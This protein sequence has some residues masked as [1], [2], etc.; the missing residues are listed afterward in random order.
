MIRKRLFWVLRRGLL[1]L[2]IGGIYSIFLQKT[3]IGF[4]C[5]INFLTGL[6]CPGCGVSHMCIALMQLDFAAAFQANPAI[7][8]LSPILAAVL[9]QYLMHYIK[10]G[11]WQMRPAQNMIL[12]FCIAVLFLYGIG[13]NLFPL[14]IG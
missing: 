1:L 6:Q 10:T 8:L 14:P 5:P 3:G 12:W 13:R 11:R 2:L 9:L 4:V 7:L